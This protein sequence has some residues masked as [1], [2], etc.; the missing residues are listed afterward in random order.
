MPEVSFEIIDYFRE[1]KFLCL[2]EALRNHKR[3]LAYSTENAF[4]IQLKSLFI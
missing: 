3:H 1:K 4:K 2:H